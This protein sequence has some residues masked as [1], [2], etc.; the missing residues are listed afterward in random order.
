M[1]NK[2]VAIVVYIDTDKNSF[3]E[4]LW[5]YRSWL[6]SGSNKRSD[7]ILFHNPEIQNGTLPEDEG[8]IHVPLAPICDQD[9]LWHD[10]RRINST[11]FLTTEEAKIVH[12]Y[13]YTFRTDI[14]T[15]LTKNFVGFRPRLATFGANVY[16]SY[17]QSVGQKITEI[18]IKYG[19]KQYSMNTDC[20]IMANSNLITEYA[21]Y[22]YQIAKRLKTEE[23]Q[24]GHGTWPGWY[25]YIIN[26]YSAG[27]AAN[28]FFRMGYAIGGL[29]C[30]SMSQDPIGSSDY[31]IHAFHTEQHFSK[32]KWREG[33]YNA[34]DFDELKGDTIAN[35]CIKMAG[36]KE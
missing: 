16:A 11:W 2:D 15:F 8:I 1:S 32:L 10:Y 25:E 33:Y 30:M 21:K 26:M 12:K 20:H 28:G 29:G 14:D 22:Q 36:K 35:Y 9:K 7:L 19:I 27:I 3:N 17:D 4:I 5:L 6:Y 24:D 34:I 31:H 18:C 23:F 13:K